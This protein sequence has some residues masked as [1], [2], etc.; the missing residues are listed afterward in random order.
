MSVRGAT[1]FAFEQRRWGRLPAVGK[2]SLALFADLCAT[3]LNIRSVIAKQRL[4]LRFE[5]R[6]VADTGPLEMRFLADFVA[7]SPSAADVLVE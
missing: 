5:R 7:A 4:E 1:S 6:K 3:K 2:T